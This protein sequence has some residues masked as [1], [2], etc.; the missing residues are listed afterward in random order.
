MKYAVCNELFGELSFEESCALAVKFGFS[1]IE[2][3]PFTLTANP[4]EFG[5]EKRSELKKTLADHGLEFV[6]LHWLLA[7]P[8]GLHLTNSDTEI[9]NKSWDF[10]KYLIDFCA[11]MG[12]GVMVIGSPKQRNAVGISVSDALSFLKQGLIQLAPFAAGANTQILLE[13]L[14]ARKTNVV[15]SMQEAADIIHEIDH[16]GISGIFDFHNCINETLSWP[17]LIGNFEAII[18]HVHLNEIDGGY[19]GSGNSDFVP[20][21]EALKE[22]NYSGWI[23]LEVFNQTESP[24]TILRETKRVI[25]TI[26][27][28]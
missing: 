15:T 13:S 18:Q 5:S 28:Q 2:L 4:Q 9:R 21:F 24:E 23:S 11:E 19:P 27:E 7:A 16:P 6:G 20:A 17:E 8:Q 26:E 3:A 12:G 22:I 1:G 14:S 10:M 25:K